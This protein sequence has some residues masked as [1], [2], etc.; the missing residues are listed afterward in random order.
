[1]PLALAGLS[2]QEL[3]I[4][5]GIVVLLF[6]ATKLPQLMRGM[7]QGIK[8]FKQ[9]VKDDSPSDDKELPAAGKDQTQP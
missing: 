1:M 8:E 6:G 7:G 2:M 5:G 9:A 4:I 3:L